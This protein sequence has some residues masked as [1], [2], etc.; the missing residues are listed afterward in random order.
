MNVLSSNVLST[1][2]KESSLG[3]KVICRCAKLL[4]AE[5]ENPNSFWIFNTYHSESNRLRSLWHRRGR[6]IDILGFPLQGLK[7]Y[8]TGAIGHDIIPHYSA[9]TTEFGKRWKVP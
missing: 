1:E 7:F 4:S 3:A 8:K 9:L 2:R 6:F 5:Y